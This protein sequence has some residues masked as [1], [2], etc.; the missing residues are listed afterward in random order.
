MSDEIKKY[1]DQ[2]AL[3][4]FLG[5]LKEAY[6]NNSAS[7][8]KVHCADVAGA[9]GASLTFKTADGNKVWN[10]SEALT[11]DISELAPVPSVEGVLKF[12]GVITS[13]GFPS[14][15]TFEEG[16]V[17]VCTE[18]YTEG[19]GASVKTYKQGSEYL[20]IKDGE[21]SGHFEELGSVIDV[22]SFATRQY[23]DDA[24]DTALDPFY[25]KDEVDEIVSDLATKAE[26]DNYVTDSELS[27]T[28]QGYIK[29]EALS[30]Y[31]DKTTVD[32]LLD[33]K[34][35]ASDLTALEGRVT[36][37][38]DAVETLEAT[39]EAIPETYATKAEVEETYT[40]KAAF[41]EHKTE[42][43]EKYV[44]KVDYVTEPEVNKMFPVEFNGGTAEEFGA[45]LTSLSQEGGGAVEVADNAVVQV[46]TTGVYGYLVGTNNEP[47]DLKIDLGEGAKLE[48]TEG[49]R[50]LSVGPGSK[51]EIDGG[52]VTC[53]ADEPAIFISN[54]SSVTLEGVTLYGK[55]YSALQSNGL[56]ENSDFYIKD[57]VIYGPCYMP[58]CGNLVIENCE[59]H[60][61]DNTS[62][63]AGALYVKSGSITIRNSKFYGD[64]VEHAGVSGPWKHNNNGWN[65]IAT[66]LVLENCNYGNHGNLKIDIDAASQ[67]FAGYC[68]TTSEA[69]KQY[70]NVGILVINYKGNH[71]A[72]GDC[73]IA[74]NYYEIDVTESTIGKH[75]FTLDGRGGTE[76]LTERVPN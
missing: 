10:G 24:I 2:A 60:A 4:T 65:G 58:A 62:A 28:L 54:D 69:G 42:A 19:E 34:A 18:D 75:Y 64:T 21:N 29:N 51:V 40:T 74:Q 22:S 32:G 1:V 68:D 47:V 23:V 36:E 72:E 41:E 70:D 73:N 6:A 46:P 45:V 49:A 20:Y 3:N 9:V 38:E 76:Q 59:F 50:V 55:N 52:E 63:D 12:K 33:A 27:D 8:F 66:A 25:T 71:C 57:C 13:E 48:A 37:V 14:G 31:Y 53:T 30:N 26:L 15:V 35:D 7:K 39:V 5:K 56:N 16:D 44:H 61:S 67:F 17:F 11:I 43:D